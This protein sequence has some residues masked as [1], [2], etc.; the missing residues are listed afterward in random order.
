M[1]SIKSKFSLSPNSK[2]DFF[3]HLDIFGQNSKLV[4]QFFIKKIFVFTDFERF[5]P[6]NEPSNILLIKL[7]IDF[8][9][10][11]KT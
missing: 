7:K 6:N 2:H 3:C 8:K 4:I 9:K 5:L 11:L 10:S 1:K